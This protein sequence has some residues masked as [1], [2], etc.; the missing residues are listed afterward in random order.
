[1]G[2]A[3][4]TGIK[5]LQTIECRGILR[6]DDQA[7]L[8]IANSACAPSLRVLDISGS[9]RITSAGMPRLSSCSSL[10]VFKIAGSR[11]VHGDAVAKAFRKGSPLRVI[12]LSGM[13]VMS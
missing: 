10:Q 13:Y 12:D 9:N 5:T 3:Y 4:I 6:M 11:R 1:M 2:I 7:L 8:N